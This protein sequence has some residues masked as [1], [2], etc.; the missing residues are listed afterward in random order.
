MSD[1]ALICIQKSPGRH[2]Q[3]RA[4]GEGQLANCVKLCDE[5]GSNYEV[6]QDAEG[7]CSGL[8]ETHRPAWGD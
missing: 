4:T 6:Y 1:L 2:E 7:D 8:S 3:D 5:N